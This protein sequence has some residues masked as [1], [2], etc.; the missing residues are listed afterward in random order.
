[1]KYIFVRNN[2]HEIWDSITPQH[3][4]SEQVRFRFMENAQRYW[5]RETVKTWTCSS[6]VWN[7][8]SAILPVFDG[9]HCTVGKR[10]KGIKQPHRSQH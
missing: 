9:D 1:M 7:T 3:E 10:A 4:P 6:K 2:C 8:A 5:R